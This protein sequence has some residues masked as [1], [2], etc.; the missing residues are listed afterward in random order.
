MNQLFKMA[1]RDLGRNRR[2]TLLSAL[3]V[4][5]GLALVLFF[6]SFIEGEMR[7]AMANTIVL[8]SGDLQVR[9][10]SYDINKMSLDWK[11]LIATPDAV[12]QQVKG[13]P[14]VADATPRLLA[15]GILSWGEDSRGVQVVGIDP[16][17]GPNEVFRQGLLSGQFITADD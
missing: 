2:R 11:D 3:A 17:A 5:L 16:Q 12:V 4:T 7:G 15:S 9:G 10:A 8:Q 13:I 6:A 14:Q 1:Y